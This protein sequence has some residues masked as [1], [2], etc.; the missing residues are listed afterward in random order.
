MPKLALTQ[1]TRKQESDLD[2]FTM[3]LAALI[4]KYSG[5]GRLFPKATNRITR[6]A[7]A[8]VNTLVLFLE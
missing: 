5:T 1:L 2:S 6:L 3:E 7:Q 4:R 8:A